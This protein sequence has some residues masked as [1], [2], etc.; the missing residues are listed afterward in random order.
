MYVRPAVE[1]F[2]TFREL[3]LANLPGPP[4]DPIAGGM[5]ICGDFPFDPCP[6]NG[7]NGDDDNGERS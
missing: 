1:R 3:T 6:G 2:G 5:T 4:A 7:D